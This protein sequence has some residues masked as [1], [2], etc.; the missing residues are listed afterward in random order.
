VGVRAVQTQICGAGEAKGSNSNCMV[1]DS[2]A[3][4]IQKCQRR[5]RGVPEP[6][7][8]SK[9]GTS[10]ILNL[11]KAQRG[12]GDAKC[13]EGAAGDRPVCGWGQYCAA[14]PLA[15]RFAI[16]RGGVR[17]RRH[18][19]QSLS[20]ALH[21]SS[22]LARTDVQRCAGER[23][24][25]SFSGANPMQGHATLGFLSEPTRSRMRARTFVHHQLSVCQCGESRP[26]TTAAGVK[27]MLWL[28]DGHDNRGY[29]CF[30]CSRPIYCSVV[31][32]KKLLRSDHST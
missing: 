7:P 17:R 32:E 21:R 29:S 4:R 9:T 19:A 10:R 18:Q 14:R 13:G 23:A 6:M 28:A 3:V 27:S 30:S 1:N 8:Q 31:E 5:A 24:W 15:S 11:W 22:G 2:K 12:E 26:S 25:L 20:S 16:P